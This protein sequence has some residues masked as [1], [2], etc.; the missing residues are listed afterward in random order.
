LYVACASGNCKTCSSPG[1]CLT[2]NTTSSATYLNLVTSSCVAGCPV[3]SGTYADTNSLPTCRGK[4]SN[5]SIIVQSSGTDPVHCLETACT[6][7]CITCTSSTCT[8]CIT[9]YHKLA[10]A[11]VGTRS[12]C[13][14]SCPYTW[15]NVSNGCAK[16]PTNC[17]I[18]SSTSVC[19]S[20]TPAYEFDATGACIASCTLGSTPN[21]GTWMTGN[22]PNMPIQPIGGNVQTNGLLP[23]FNRSNVPD[24]PGTRT[25]AGFAGGNSSYVLYGG[26]LG[27]T[28]RSD[29]WRYDNGQPE[30]GWISSVWE[31]QRST[32]YQPIVGPAYALSTSEGAGAQMRMHGFPV[33]QNDA[34]M[35]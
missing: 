21:Q 2:C 10:P 27:T 18:C 16:C 17:D 20:C 11:G 24:L 1:V 30:T 29:L 19:T 33:T 9:G 26:D 13:Y 31:A 8:T 35:M 28:A 15:M 25:S 7:N 12:Y 22:C 23:R 3:G 5:H 6:P 32:K 4:L 34:K 14:A